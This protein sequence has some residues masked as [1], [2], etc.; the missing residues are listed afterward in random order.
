MNQ[1]LRITKNEVIIHDRSDATYLVDENIHATIVIVLKPAEQTVTIRLVGV[2]A[3]AH[4]I[5]IGLFTGND[6]ARLHTLQHHEARD[7]ASNL[8]VKAVLNDSASFVFDGSIIVDKKAQKTNAYQRNENLLLSDQAHVQSKPALEILANDVRCT[9]G[10]TI[11]TIDRDQLFYLQTRG[12][13]E[14]SAKRLLIQ[15][16]LEAPF[17][18]LSDTIQTNHPDAKNAIVRVKEKVWQT[19]SKQLRQAI[20]HQEV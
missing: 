16:F 13:D 9:H 12:I 14:F 4:I 11:G 1:E 3:Q 15:G 18:A 5:G 10:A 2:G 6:H 19:L 8:L 7:T 20:S 17:I